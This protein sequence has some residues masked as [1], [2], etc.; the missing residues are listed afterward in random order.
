MNPIAMLSIIVAALAAFG[1]SADRRWQLLHVGGPANRFDRI[2]ERIARVL[3]YGIKQEK[4]HKYRGAGLAHH[5]VFAGFGI[6]LLRTIILWGRGFEPAF[7][8]FFFSPGQPLGDAYGLLKDGIAILVIAGAS[9]FLY[10][11][12]LVKP[13]RMTISGEAILILV[14]IMTMMVSDIF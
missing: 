8:A 2:G 1:W 10:L 4:M 13:A 3:R 12:T 14:I 11:R 7:G 9:Y 5:V 6:L